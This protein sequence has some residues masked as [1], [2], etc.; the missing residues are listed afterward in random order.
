MINQIT[1]KEVAEG[2]KSKRVGRFG[3]GFITTHLLS[4]VT[5]VKGIVKAVDG[6]FYSFN[7]PLDREGKTTHELAPKVENTWQWF[8]SSTKKV[9]PLP[10]EST[11]FHTSFI[12][13]LKTERQ[14]E[15]AS[16]GIEE[17]IRLMPYV[18]TFVSNIGTIKICNGN[19]TFLFQNSNELRDDFIVDIRKTLNGVVSTVPVAIAEGDTVAVA[20]EIDPETNEAKELDDTPHIFCD[21]PL[22]GT[23]GFHFPV[24][25]NSFHFI[26][27]TERNGIWLKGDDD[28]EV[29]TNKKLLKNAV[30]QYK[31]LLTNLSEKGVKNLFNVVNTRLPDTDEDSFDKTWYEDEIQEPLRQIILKI[32]VVDTQGKGRLPIEWTENGQVNYVDFPHA[33]SKKIRE[34]IWKLGSN[35]GGLNLPERQSTDKWRKVIWDDHYYLSLEQLSSIISQWF[36][37][38][39]EFTEN[40]SADQDPFEW[41]NTFYE[42]IVEEK[43]QN[44]FNEHAIIPNQNGGFRTIKEKKKFRPSTLLFNDEVQDD[45]LLSILKL[46]GIDWK[47]YLI[48]NEITASVTNASINKQHVATEIAKYFS[49]QNGEMP[50]DAV[51]AIVLLS[52]WFEHNPQLGKEIFPE[53]Y[54]RRAGLFMNTIE[55]KDCLYHVMKSKT[56]LST[57]SEI[58]DAIEDDPE[59][60]ALIRRKKH[61]LEEEK[62]RNKAGELVEE[63]L[64]DL[65]KN[66]GL[67][68]EKRIIG[69]D[70]VI[71][72]K[73]KSTYDIEVKSIKAGN[74]VTLSP[75]QA[76]TAVSRPDFYALCVVSV[77]NL[78]VSMDQVKLNAR[79]V[80]DIGHLIIEKVHEMQAFN[81][82]QAS[83]LDSDGD[84]GLLFE[85]V[86]NYKYKIGA[87]VWKD[88]VDF[89]GFLKFLEGLR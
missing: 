31:S 76:N 29:H 32:P 45:T 51:R 78:P 11:E 20:V 85:N 46:L 65:L 10:P 13:H 87:P 69:R 9:P 33:A 54:R 24:I 37:N 75:T 60:L 19:Q 64:S 72:L 14:R 84:I 48:P 53:L 2:E 68:V 56:P 43:E 26:P 15:I 16:K 88:G 62:A 12:Y 52:E 70:L 21:F 30:E 71:T 74:F 7:F 63:I 22:I 27:R 8:Q 39:G 61:E 25:V 77:G 3:T 38:L 66:S 81:R 73:G 34:S 80:T 41:L 50:K 28:P 79:F 44:I 89:E 59:I 23:E 86:L 17:F 1:S 83:I 55:D 67:S 58:V 57:I 42:L 49:G 40:L 6:Q 35:F 82:T 4:R 36:D 18:L 5:Q 47:E